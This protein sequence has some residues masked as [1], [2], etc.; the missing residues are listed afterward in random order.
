MGMQEAEMPLWHPHFLSAGA[1]S[2]LRKLQPEM[3]SGENTVR[4][5]TYSHGRMISCRYWKTQL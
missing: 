4:C 3:L 5:L 2:C 1:D